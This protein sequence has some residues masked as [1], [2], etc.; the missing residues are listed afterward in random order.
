MSNNIMIR[1]FFCRNF[2]LFLFKN[3]K[4][5][6]KKNPSVFFMNLIT[7]SRA[8]LYG[9]AAHY[10]IKMK[11]YEDVKKKWEAESQQEK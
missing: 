11:N 8:F 3:K 10:F 7:L 6:D 2:F 9:C 1:F 4:N 5:A